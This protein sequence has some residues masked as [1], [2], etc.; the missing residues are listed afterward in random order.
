MIDACPSSLAATLK[1]WD[2]SEKASMNSVDVK[3]REKIKIKKGYISIKVH[4][5]QD[6]FLDSH[7]ARIDARASSH[8]RAIPDPTSV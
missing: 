2:V 3:V 1:N 6:I 8:R 7:L 5:Y 4:T